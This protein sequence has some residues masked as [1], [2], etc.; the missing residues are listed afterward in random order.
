[1]QGCLQ[2]TNYQATEIETDSVTEPKSAKLRQRESEVVCRSGGGRALTEMAK[3]GSALLL[4]QVAPTLTSSPSSYPLPAFAFD[5][6]NGKVI[7][8]CGQYYHCTQ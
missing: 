4:L 3:V 1:M 7:G 5:Q 8:G 2:N 6:D